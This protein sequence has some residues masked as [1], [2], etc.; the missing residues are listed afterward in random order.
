MYDFYNDV[1]FNTTEEIYEQDK[2]MRKL[3][4]VG[5]VLVYHQESFMTYI[6]DIQISYI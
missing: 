6:S 1:F 4:H 5:M 2:Q 3:G